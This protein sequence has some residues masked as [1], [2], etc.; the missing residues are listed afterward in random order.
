M[1]KKLRRVVFRRK[2]SRSNVVTLVRLVCWE[3]VLLSGRLVEWSVFNELKSPGVMKWRKENAEHWRTTERCSA[4]HTSGQSQ[5]PDN[6]WNFK[7][8]FLRGS[9]IPRRRT[10]CLSSRCFGISWSSAELKIGTNSLRE[11]SDDR[12]VYEMLASG[13]G[14][15]VSDLFSMIMFRWSLHSSLQWSHGVETHGRL[16]KHWCQKRSFS[17]GPCECLMGHESGMPLVV[18]GLH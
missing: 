2:N 8:D 16:W 12:V 7:A 18:I 5:R 11:T 17:V 15:K 3:T 9:I 4:R 13:T 6:N 14:E 10:P 1:D